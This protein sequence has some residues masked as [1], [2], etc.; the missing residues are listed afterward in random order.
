[1]SFS[2]LPTKFFFSMLAK[3]QLFFFT[4][5]KI[6]IAPGKDFDSS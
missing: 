6:G 3:T 5:K 4:P 1:M 2:Y